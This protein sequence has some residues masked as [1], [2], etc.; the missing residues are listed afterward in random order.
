MVFAVLLLLLAIIRTVDAVGLAVIAVLAAGITLW[1]A[2]APAAT[3][4]EADDEAP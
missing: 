4:D 1:V 2:R 3:S